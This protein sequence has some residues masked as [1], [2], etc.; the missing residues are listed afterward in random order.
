MEY[1]PELMQ[2]LCSSV[3]S[4]DPI[5]RI[6]YPQIS[7]VGSDYPARGWIFQGIDK[8]VNI[9]SKKVRSSGVSST[10][11]MFTIEYFVVTTGLQDLGYASVSR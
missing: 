5:L 11:R 3:K 1:S 10:E 6:F 4:V 7:Q 8:K 2:N 9:S